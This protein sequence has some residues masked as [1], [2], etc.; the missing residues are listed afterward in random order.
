[1][2]L[3]DSILKRIYIRYT[4]PSFN[5]VNWEINQ[6]F[7]DMPREYDA[8]SLKDSYLELDF[9]VN[10]SAGGHARHTD[11]D[12]IRLVNLG[13]LALF[14]EYRLTSSN[15]NEIDNAH[16]CSVYKLISSSRDSDDLSVG[17]HRSIEARGR[18]LTNKKTIKG[19]YHVFFE[20]FFWFC[21]TSK[22][23]FILFGIQICITK[24]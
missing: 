13:P 23:C 6:I 19:N 18:E 22:K 17:F 8:I 21:R 2:L 24:K 3:I 12:R 1:M 5:L 9:N 4:P 14:N 10:A 16:V 11:G 20:R 7:I 15:G